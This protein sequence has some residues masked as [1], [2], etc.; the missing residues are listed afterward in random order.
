M[1]LPINI[2]DI[3]HGKAVEWERLEFKGWR[4]HLA[5]VAAG[6]FELR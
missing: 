5:P 1:P 6:Q 4:G 2:S 3:L